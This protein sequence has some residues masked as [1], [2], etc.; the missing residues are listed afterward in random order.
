[1]SDT[2]ILQ[3]VYIERVFVVKEISKNI[4]A[5]WQWNLEAYK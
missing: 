3:L 4:V 5:S 1:M 2:E